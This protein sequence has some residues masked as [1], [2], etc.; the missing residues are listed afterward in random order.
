MMNI[1]TPTCQESRPGQSLRLAQVGID[2]G[3]GDAMR[4]SL[5]GTLHS[6]KETAKLPQVH[7]FA[8]TIHSAFPEPKPRVG[9][10]IE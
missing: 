2:V 4:E 6:Q 9:I 7:D 3:E 1:R 5:F 8:S 10:G